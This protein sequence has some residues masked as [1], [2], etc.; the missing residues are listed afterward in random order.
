MATTVRTLQNFV[1]GEW[2]ESTGEH[3]RQ[4][5]SPVTGETLAEVPD[6]GPEDVARAARAARKAQPR[7]AA[8]SAWDRASICHAIADL[9]DERKE[10]VARELT[11]EQGKPFAAE[12]IPDIEETAENF[13]IAA[14]DVKRMETA[15][16]PSQDVNKRI[17]TFRKPNGVYAGITP[18]NFPT[19]IPV[20]L[21]APGIAA[22]NT[23]VMKPSEW[24]PIAMATFMQAMADAGLPEGVVNVVYGGGEVGE[25]LITDE[26]IDCVGFVGSHTTA[27]KIVRAA[28]LKRTLIEAS[29]NGP[30]IVCEDADLQAA[31]KGAVFGGFFCAGQVCCATERVLVD[32]NV[33]DDFLQAV[34][35][36]AGDWKLGDPFD[37]DT[38]VGPMNNEP[39]AQKMDRHLEDAVEKGA[40]VVLGGSRDSERPTELYYQPTVV[41]AVGVDTLI[42]RDETFGPIV[43]LITVAGD[44][45]ALEVANDSHL[46]L[47]AAVYTSSLKRAFRYLDNLR[48]GNVVVNDSTDYWEAHEP[49]GGASG[50]RT[51]WGR[52]GGRYTMLDMT[53][54]KTAVLDVGGLD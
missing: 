10:D 16:I 25:R 21:I 39:T 14:E 33:H 1:G 29:G 40:S 47:Q 43:P 19:L 20:E 35:D 7:W 17:L 5:V 8:L 23:I 9:I 42:N 2:V 36:E 15:I 38:L 32:R 6:A 27:E 41:D 3:V 45:E 12:A 37:D 31:A 46:G 50:T 11:L 54:L 52:I 24:T 4:I 18:W 44:D 48:V 13:R 49:F 34:V 53:D 51:G 22:G 30:V 28:G 26:N